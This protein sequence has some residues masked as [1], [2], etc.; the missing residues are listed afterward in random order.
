MRPL[1]P[2]DAIRAIEVTARYPL[3]HGAP[4][5]IGKPEA[6]GVDPDRPME[7]LGGIRVADDELPLFW[8]CGVTPQRADAG[9]GRIVELTG[10]VR[11]ARQHDGSLHI[12]ARRSPPGVR[13][14]T[15][16]TNICPRG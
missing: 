4:V 14:G 11:A 5:H 15:A 16:R 1:R 2:L 13:T 9:F 10:P 12:S 6:I 7:T 3:V 8:A